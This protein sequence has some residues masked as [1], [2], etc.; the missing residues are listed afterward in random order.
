MNAIVCSGNDLYNDI[1]ND[2]RRKPSLR[3]GMTVGFL[4]DLLFFFQ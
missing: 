2:C 3:F 4:W 1:D